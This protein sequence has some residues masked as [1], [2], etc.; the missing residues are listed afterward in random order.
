MKELP[1]ARAAL[2]FASAADVFLQEEFEALGE[3][4]IAT[5]DGSAGAKGLVTELMAT[6]DH[7]YVF[8]CGPEPMMRAVHALCPRGQFSFEGRMAC[9]FGACMGCSCKT[10]FGSKRVCVDGP[11]LTGEEIAW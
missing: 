5:I 7:D 1:G 11:V 8:V 4:R 2:G 3:V 6:L 10:N 9:G